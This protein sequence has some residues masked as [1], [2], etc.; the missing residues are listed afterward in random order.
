MDKKIYDFSRKLLGIY[1]PHY[2]CRKL[3]SKRN[4]FE[5]NGIKTTEIS[6]TTMKRIIT[7]LA[8]V[9]AACFCATAQ[10]NIYMPTL[11]ENSQLSVV[12]DIFYV[13]GVPVTDGT[14][15]YLLGEDVYNNEYLPAKKK[16][17]TAG[18]L[19]YIGGTIMGIG[20][21]CAAGDLIVS[22]IYG[23][24]LN[25]RSYA[26][27]GCVTALGLIPTLIHFQ[28]AKNGRAEY[29]RIAESYNKNT[30]KVTG[31][32]LTPARSGFGIAINF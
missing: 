19:G 4:G 8:T 6:F 1:P 29:T 15:L 23:N 12:E 17:Q 18:A 10:Q 27:Y 20:L 31:L 26:V 13:D 30:G 16:F 3:W 21:G 7:T 14:L 9:I 32:T 11:N 5:S 25:G 28:I 24:P 22:A 2:I